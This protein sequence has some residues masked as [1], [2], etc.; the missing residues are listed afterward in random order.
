MAKNM[1]IAG[2]DFPDVVEFAESMALAGYGVIVASLPVEN[3][4]LTSKDIAVLPWNKGSAL[5]ARSVVIQAETR[6]GTVDEYVLYF[7]TAS[8]CQRFDN[9]RADTCTLAADAM[10]LSYQYLAMEILNRI[11]QKKENAKL[12]FVLKT[13]L[14]EKEGA[15]NPTL[16]TANAVF[17]NPIVASA[18]AAFAT[19][20]ENIASMYAEKGNI[21]I[22][23]ISGDEENEV[24]KKDSSFASWLTSYLESYD[25]L[26]H[27]P[28][29][30]NT[31]T[32]VRAGAKNPGGFSLFR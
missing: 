10:V 30:K 16:R 13:C 8:F 6:T 9:L 20:A 29:L 21:S 7:D 14:S 1:L 24:M 2:K 19:F 15:L 27:K 25:Q 31:L 5:A 22:V 18:E 11:Q 4:G 32:W 17:A 28:N 12:V 23:L 3:T 26:K